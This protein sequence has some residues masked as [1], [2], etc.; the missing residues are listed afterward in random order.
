MQTLRHV[1]LSPLTDGRTFELRT[2]DTGRTDWR[3][4]TVIAFRFGVVDEPPI[5]EGAD[6]AGSPLTAD[7]SDQCLATLLTFLTLRPGDTDRDYFDD[8]TPEQLDWT[9]DYACES[10]SCD[11]ATFEE[12]A[13]DNPD[14]VPPWVDVDDDA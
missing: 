7:D 2:W 8:Y 1:R 9:Q 11:V 14:A 13:R 3:G 5:F 10:L 6:F 4:Q 12:D